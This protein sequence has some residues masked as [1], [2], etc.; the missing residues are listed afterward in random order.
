MKREMAPKPKQQ[1]D[2]SEIVVVADDGSN[3][4]EDCSEEAKSHE[5]PLVRLELNNI[6]YAPVTRSSS[7]KKNNHNA[8]SSRT[9][10]LSNIT[11][12]ISP[13]QVTAWM[14][15]SGSGKTSLISVAANLIQSG[16]I[17]SG[18]MLIN[19]DP[20]IVPKNL[21][22]VVW[23]EDLLL[24]NLTV[25]E[26]IYFSAR[27]KTSC[28][29]SDEQVKRNV[30]DVMEEL[31]LMHVRNSL[32]GGQS[33][34][35]ISGGERKRVAVASELV[36]RPSLLLLDEPTSGL[37]AT[38]AW[39]LI[40]TLRDLAHQGGLAIAVVIHQPRTEIFNMFDHLLLLNHGRTVYNGH[41]KQAR[42]YLEN[43]PSV[44]PLPP[45]TGIADWLMDIIKADSGTTHTNGEGDSD[46][47]L[48]ASHWCERQKVN[49]LLA[50]SE[51]DNS[52]P[53]DQQ[54]STVG[55]DSSTNLKLP[56][57]YHRMSSLKELQKS[58]KYVTPFRM[59]LK[60]L[61]QRTLKQMR[62]EKFTRI[63]ILLTFAYTF[64]T[65]LFW[66]RLPDNTSR[67]YDRI[68]LLFFMLVA[69]ANGIVTASISVFERERA[70]L[71]RDRAK[72]LYGV[73]PFFV[74]K[75]S[76]DMTNNVLLP[77]LYG[78]V[79][80]YA[81]G[82]RPEFEYFAKF[83]LI[84]YLTMS[85]AQS[86]GLFLSVLIPSMSMALILAPPI[87]L[88]FI[89]MGG[90]Y[91]PF[92]NMHPGVLWL[93]WLSFARYGYSSMLVNEFQGRDIP[94][95]SDVGDTISVSIGEPGECPLPGDDVLAKLGIEGIS[96]NFWFGV[97]I[98]TLL[99]VAFRVA[100]YAVLRRSNK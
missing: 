17:T 31:G 8:E 37:D 97:G 42:T 21:V 35:G 90:F 41:P 43:V 79:C 69:Q 34:R 44:T 32:L 64:F 61:T 65:A 50:S 5:V 88:F 77:C 18:E 91:I 54:R 66:W 16:D 81:C 3:A 70:L 22:G 60:L 46:E 71:R 12:T 47:S 83:V 56:V 75:T 30:E 48:L 72:K 9:T 23:Q 82:F 98:I 36:V 1:D 33:Q 39:T 78:A 24:S 27:L 96:T 15:P 13:Y 92:E 95:A 40:S 20:G 57:L 19:G 85:A 52:P 76:S 87:T 67:V 86:M 38:T 74:A 10:I 62:G 45:E 68:S 93:S 6:T 11:T 29:S 73:L 2:P 89:I 99:Q 14:G 84:Y 28:D 4:G 59:Q 94:C 58:P 53:S 51:Q 7:S 25:E 100:S 49:P 63:A 26:T 55:L 80:Y